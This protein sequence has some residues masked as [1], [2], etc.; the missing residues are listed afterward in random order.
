M[1]TNA[2]LISLTPSGGGPTDSTGEAPMC[3]TQMIRSAPSDSV[4]TFARRRRP[5]APAGAESF[6][7]IEASGAD[8]C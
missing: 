2:T 4:K 8:P 6:G 5:P 7:S 3:R 1:R